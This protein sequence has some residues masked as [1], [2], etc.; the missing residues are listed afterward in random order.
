MKRFQIVLIASVLA[1]LPVGEAMAAHA[2]TPV[3]RPSTTA[4]AEPPGASCVRFGTRFKATACIRAG[5]KQK[6][7]ASDTDLTNPTDIG[8]GTLV[9]VPCTSTSTCLAVEGLLDASGWP[10][11]WSGTPCAVRRAPG[12]FVAHP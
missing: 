10:V 9:G 8:Q 6:G 5:T 1:A 3:T 12:R 11:V 7:S 4:R 2:R